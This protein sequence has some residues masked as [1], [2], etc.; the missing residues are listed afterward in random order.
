MGVRLQISTAV[1]QPWIFFSAKTA[2]LDFQRDAFIKTGICAFRLVCCLFPLQ[3]DALVHST[4]SRQCY[5]AMG[6]DGTLVPPS[7]QIGRRRLW[8]LL[9]VARWRSG[10][11]GRHTDSSDRFVSKLENLYWTL[12]NAGSIVS[13]KILTSS[14]WWE[15]V[16]L[17]E[18]YHWSSCAHTLHSISV[19]W[20]K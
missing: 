1:W 7:T 9:N 4:Q 13:S 17:H 15:S 19:V 5:L 8:S 16:Q 6:A 11:G 14:F 12:A 20:V 3:P 18:I 10:E 2:R